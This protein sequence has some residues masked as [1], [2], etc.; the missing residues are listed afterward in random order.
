M[1]PFYNVT[2]ALMIASLS[3]CLCASQSSICS[4]K[5][6]T[7]TS[8]TLKRLELEEKHLKGKADLAELE[9]TKKRLS[10]VEGLVNS[11]R[12]QIED[13]EAHRH[14]LRLALIKAGITL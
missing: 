12:E 8:K 9:E 7:S 13:C 3:S 11:L 2:P 14:E 6:L 5:E 1:T 4:R 10:V